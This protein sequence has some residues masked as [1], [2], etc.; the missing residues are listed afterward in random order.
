[1]SSIIEN[2]NCTSLGPVELTYCEGGCLSSSRF[3]FD[4]EMMDGDC[5]CCR[6]FQSTNRT[7]ELTCLDNTTTLYSYIYVE[8][9]SCQ[10]PEC[11]YLTPTNMVPYNV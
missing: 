2:Q 4:S 6:P 3:S 9:C 1:M 11:E 5:T 8:E 10:I 7:V